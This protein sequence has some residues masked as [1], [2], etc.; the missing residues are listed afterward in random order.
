MNGI[1]VSSGANYPGFRIIRDGRF[2]VMKTDFGLEA[3]YDGNMYASV[4][5]PNTYRSQLTGLCGNC[6]GNVDNDWTT[7]DGQDI[8]N[9]GNRYNILG[10]SYQVNDPKDPK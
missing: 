2:M 4:F 3:K 10:N 6:D 7:M 5:V 9:D 8:R 1:R